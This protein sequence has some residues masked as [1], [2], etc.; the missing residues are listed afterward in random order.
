MISKKP[1]LRSP[2]RRV[3]T[4]LWS[5]PQVV[6]AATV[7]VLVAANVAW[8]WRFRYGFPLDVDE[9]GYLA[10]ALDNTAA[11]ES[12]G[13]MGLWDAYIRQHP[14]APLVPLLTVPFELLFGY[15]T[16]P[17]FLLQ[18]CFFVLLVLSS[19]GIGRRLTTPAYGVLTAV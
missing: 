5:W 2:L 4:F 7:G 12:E 13:I 14:Q 17:G 8:L 9:A 1:D 10:T 16:F 6:V 18:E 11:F 3:G 15:G 19:Y